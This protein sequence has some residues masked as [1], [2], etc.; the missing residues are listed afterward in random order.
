MKKVDFEQEIQSAE[1]SEK[2]DDSASYNEP[3]V[4]ESDTSLEDTYEKRIVAF[5]DILGFSSEVYA[6][7]KDAARARKIY[8]ALTYSHSNWKDSF[9][10]RLSKLGINHPLDQIDLRVATFSDSVVL[11]TE[12]SP[13][14][15]GLLIHAIKQIIHAHLTCGFLTR[16]GVSL[17]ELHHPDTSKQQDD[18]ARYADRIFG[19]A[20]IKAYTLESQ[21]ANS[22][23]VIICNDLRKQYSSW[24]VQ[25]EQVV[26]YLDKT[27]VQAQDG[28]YMI[29][30]FSMFEGRS[31]EEVAPSMKEISSMLKNGLHDY[32][33]SPKVFS[34]YSGLAKEFNRYVS[35]LRQLSRDQIDEIKIDSA[36]LPLR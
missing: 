21:F 33:E 10:G 11:S 25:G 9:V 20:F 36:Y 18:Q 2:S 28:P 7:S 13:L 22:A 19:P 1:S 6:S 8:E 3:T 29:D 27:L 17:G 15:F 14:N 31:A 35:E 4:P 32:T 16:G 30:F 5:I 24:K 12:S 23:R 26:R 34:K